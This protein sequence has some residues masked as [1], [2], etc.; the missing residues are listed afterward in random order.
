MSQFQKLEV[1]GESQA[2]EQA[3]LWLDTINSVNELRIHFIKKKW[4]KDEG[5]HQ[6]QC[7]IKGRIFLLS[8]SNL[9][10]KNMRL[11][12]ETWKWLL[13]SGAGV[14]EKAGLKTSI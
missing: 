9:F 11:E 10:F 5:K 12:E 8:H 2:E 4:R 6:N 14:R 1:T 7:S 13:V 3:L